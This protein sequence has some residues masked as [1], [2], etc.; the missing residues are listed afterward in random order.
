MHTFPAGQ[1][2]LDLVVDLAGVQV[3]VGRL[4]QAYGHLLETAPPMALH[5]FFY[6][7]DI[8]IYTYTGDI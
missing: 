6:T 4:Q 2:C 1:L 7:G 3:V 5:P 8:Y